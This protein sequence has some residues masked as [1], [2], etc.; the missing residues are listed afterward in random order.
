LPPEFPARL[1][2]LF[3]RDARVGVVIRRGP[4][5][6]VATLLWDRE[7]DTFELGQ[8]LKGRIYERRCDLSPDGKHLLYFAMNGRWQSPVGGSWTAISRA[9]YLKAIVLL[10]KGDCWNGG[11]LWTKCDRYWLNDGQHAHT[12]MY[13]N[14]DRL[15]RQ[16]RRSRPGESFG[17]EC[18]GVYYPRLQ[19]DGWHLIEHLS[20]SKHEDNTIF[21]KPVSKDWLLRKVA[22]GQIG[23]PP[24]KGCYWDEHQLMNRATG[25][26][27]P[28]PDWEW[29]ERDGGRLV[30]ATAGKLFAGRVIDSGLA[31]ETELFD[32]NPLKF[33]AIKA[34]Y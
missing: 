1:H 8:W 2:V 9:P 17:G 32:F 28:Q 19:R 7:R 6:Q 14:S 12:L 16:D 34:P 23:S 30:W 5:K 29:A 21:E 31:N 27:I 24:G 3:A 22:H 15:L 4:A 11:G 20:V 25:E 26:T 18:P 33:E 10:G 13:D